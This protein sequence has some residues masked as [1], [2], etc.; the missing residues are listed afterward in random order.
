[1]SDTSGLGE[2]QN[3]VKFD[4][5]V[6]T[7]FAA[8]LREAAGK[9]TTFEGER[10]HAESMASA[11]FRGFFSQVFRQNMRVCSTDAAE[12]STAFTQTAAE[13]EYLAGEARKE[14][15]RRQQVRDYVASHA[16]E[17]W[18]ER[19]VHA[20]ADA[21]QEIGHDLLGSNDTPLPKATPPASRWVKPPPRR[22]HGKQT[23]GYGGLLEVSRVRFQQI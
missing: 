22:G 5:A 10:G 13:V 15:E 17:N 20:F 8:K 19:G 11:E 4:F 23:R 1:M 2:Y 9:V 18:L 16:N 7:E 21:I 6:A 12:L 3:P 14:N